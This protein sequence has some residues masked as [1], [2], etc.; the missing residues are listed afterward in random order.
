[1][2]IDNKTS[3]NWD[4]FANEFLQVLVKKQEIIKKTG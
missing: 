1:M 2:N 4:F 3:I